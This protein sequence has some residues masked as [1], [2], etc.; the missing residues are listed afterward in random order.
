MFL[1]NSGENI[2]F[3]YN[4]CDVKKHYKTAILNLL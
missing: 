1:K 4:C 3:F 2:G